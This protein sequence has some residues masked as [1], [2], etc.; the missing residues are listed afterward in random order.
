MWT[1]LLSWFARLVIPAWVPIVTAAVVAAS[2]TWTIQG[3]RMDSMEAEYIKAKADALTEARMKEQDWNTKIQESYKKGQE[4]ETAI[5]TKA[6]NARAAA[7]KLRIELQRIQMS[8]SSGSTSDKRTSTLTDIL[9]DCSTKYRD[10]AEKA[11][12]HVSDKQTLIEAWPK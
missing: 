7:D 11:D 8:S 10:L 5:R 1:A 12:R 6:S 9:G 2:A 3:W 4:R